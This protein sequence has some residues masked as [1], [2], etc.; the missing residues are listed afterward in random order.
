MRF[1]VNLINWYWDKVDATRKLPL[2]NYFLFFLGKVFGGFALGLLIASY[3]AGIDW[4]TV[5]WSI[6]A[7]SLL[8]SLP[9]IPK[10]FK[11]KK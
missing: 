10:I 11:T 6:L 9:S 1:K 7:A 8:I 4:I 2:K 5:G 3:I